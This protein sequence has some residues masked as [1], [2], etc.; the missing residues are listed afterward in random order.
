FAT[1]VYRSQASGR[2][3]LA[4]VVAAVLDEKP[5]WRVLHDPAV[6]ES[7][8]GVAVAP[9]ALELAVLTQNP[10]YGPGLRRALERAIRDTAAEDRERAERERR[11]Q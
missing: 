5:R 10:D 9:G 11:E 6:V 7:R 8:V 1:A 2:P 3:V 4:S